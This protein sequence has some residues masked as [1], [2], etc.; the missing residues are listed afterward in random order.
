MRFAFSM[1][2]VFMFAALM[3]GA[4]SFA[5]Q[6]ENMAHWFHA[7]I[8]AD[9]RALALIAALDDPQELA[10]QIA[11]QTAVSGQD[12]R[13]VSFVPDDVDMTPI[14]NVRVEEQFLG[15]RH[16]NIGD[17]IAHFSSGPNP[18]ERLVGYGMDVGNG[19]LMSG[20]TSTWFEEQRSLWLQSYSWGLGATM[21]LSTTIA[22]FIGHRAAKR[23]K[24]METVLDAVGNGQYG[25]RIRDR[26]RDDLT[27]LAGSVDCAL[28]RLDVGISAIRQV[29][30]D[31]AHDLRAPIS[32][33]RL[34]LEAIVTEPNL[35][36]DIRK[37]LGQTLTNVDQVTTTFDAILRLAHMQAGIVQITPRPVD[38]TILCQDV[39]DLMEP[40][41]EH[42]GHRLTLQVNTPG[43]VAGDGDLLAQAL[44]NLVQNSI[45]HCLAPAN[46]VIELKTHAEALALSVC[47]DG[48]GVPERDL[49]R[50]CDRFV[51]LDKSRKGLGCGLGLSLVREIAKLHTAQFKLENRKPGLCARISFKQS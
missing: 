34:Q 20:R 8:E 24:R 30:T 28:A 40:F 36:D 1:S 37:K 46:I 47:D 15:L 7:E 32:R 18:S 43:V 45:E 16:F 12:G 2:L 48:P 11:A 4:V 26:G 10:N 31:V 44:S 17:G 13:V 9:T 51:R 22:L 50:V 14:G 27:T 42:H 38:L 23:I 6:I 19:W 5:L 35:S 49:G 25:L 3:T 39:F 33:L 29:S 21:L 41:A